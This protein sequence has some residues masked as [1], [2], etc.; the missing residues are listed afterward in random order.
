[1]YYMLKFP[2]L[3]NIQNFRNIFRDVK[4]TRSET[5]YDHLIKIITPGKE[6]GK[7]TYANT[8]HV[9]RAE[10]TAW[11]ITKLLIPVTSNTLHECFVTLK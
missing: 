5:N 2:V 10:H 7:D 9:T 6:G 8:G 4:H 1:M 3:V 11:K